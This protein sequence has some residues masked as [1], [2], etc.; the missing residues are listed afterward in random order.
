[1]FSHWIKFKPQRKERKVHWHCF[2][3]VK[4]SRGHSPT[5]FSSNKYFDSEHSKQFV[6]NGPLH[7]EHDSLHAG[8]FYLFCFIL[9]EYS[10]ETIKEKRKITMTKI[11]IFVTKI[12]TFQSGNTSC[13][14]Q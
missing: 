10:N 14:I 6:D 1:M 9:F 12:G 5:H 2:P 11:I 8:C 4:V 7:F 3:E 13:W